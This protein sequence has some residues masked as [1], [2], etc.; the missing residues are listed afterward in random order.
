MSSRL[1]RRWASMATRICVSLSWLRVPIECAR[2]LLTSSCVCWT[3]TSSAALVRSSMRLLC[4]YFSDL[5]WPSMVC[6][7]M[8]IRASRPLGVSPDREPVRPDD[9]SRMS[10]ADDDDERSGL[11]VSSGRWLEVDMEEEEEAGGD[12]NSEGDPADV[13]EEEKDDEEDDEPSMCGGTDCGEGGSM[14]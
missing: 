5:S 7:S 3:L 1:D 13:E 14:P 2:C 12:S 11:G 8:L 9:D 6:S 10:A 4:R